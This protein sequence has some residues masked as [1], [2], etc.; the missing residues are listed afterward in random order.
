MASINIATDLLV[1]ALPV[2]AI[3][4]L[5]LIRKQKIALIALMTLGWSYVLCFHSSLLF[6]DDMT[7]FVS[8]H[9]FGSTL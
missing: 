1:A 2:R 7:G 3:W 5:Q 6:T 8:S 9:A 4:R